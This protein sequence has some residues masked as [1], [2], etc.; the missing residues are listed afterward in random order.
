[1]AIAALIFILSIL[2]FVGGETQ[3]KHRLVKDIWDAGHLVL[4]GLLSYSYFNRP[5]KA[6]V[7]ISYKIVF[8]T[9]VGLILGA[10]IEALQL[11][12]HREFSR[13]D[14]I[15]DV[16]GGYLGLLSLS[17]L[18]KRQALTRR[19]IATAI[20]VIFLAAGLRNMGKHLLDEIN[21]RKQFP[22]LASF[23]SR[24][25]IERWEHKLVNLKLSQQ[26]IKS[27]LYSLEVEYLRGRYP[28]ISL[29]HFKSDW[30]GY[31]KL[32]FS[33]YNPSHQELKFSIN[34]YD[35][36]HI[37]DGR[38]YND[39]FSKSVTLK[40]GWNNIGISLQDIIKA[41]RRRYMNIHRIKGFSLF[42]DRLE[43]PVT[44]YIDDLHLL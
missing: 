19:I 8:T 40:P 37:K 9:S 16:I 11:L 7:S 25:E 20:L 28:N 17:I 4:F 36:K 41:P 23:E 6:G 1:M 32:E 18:D 26:Y 14:I 31:N 38:K 24:L 29:K 34:V 12:V 33:V 30:S 27:G 13:G 10:A 22:V 44:I 35:R 42:T 2:L 15:N 3:L 43:Q 39:R 21:M 5:T